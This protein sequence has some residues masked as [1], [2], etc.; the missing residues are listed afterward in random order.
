MFDMKAIVWVTIDDDVDT[1]VVQMTPVNLLKRDFGGEIFL[2]D[3]P[4]NIV[5]ELTVG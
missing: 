2:G 5:S 1:F 4:L 3:D